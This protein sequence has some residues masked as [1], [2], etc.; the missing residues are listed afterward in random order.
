MEND[1]KDDEP[2]SIESLRRFLVGSEKLCK[3][4]KDES[5]KAG[6]KWLMPM[7]KGLLQDKIKLESLNKYNQY[8]GGISLV[9]NDMVPIAFHKIYDREKNEWIIKTSMYKAAFPL[10]TITYESSLEDEPVR[11]GQDGLPNIY[12]LQD[13]TVLGYRSICFLEDDYLFMIGWKKYLASDID[14][15]DSACPTP[16][17]H[18]MRTDIF[19]LMQ[20]FKFDSTLKW[21]NKSRQDIISEHQRLEQRI[22]AQNP[23]GDFDPLFS[24][25]LSSQTI[26]ALSM[27]LLKELKQAYQCPFGM[28][29]YSSH[30]ER[31]FNY[32]S[33]SV[34]KLNYLGAVFPVF[35]IRRGLFGYQTETII[36]LNNR[37][38]IGP[39]TSLL[40]FME[41]CFNNDVLINNDKKLFDFILKWSGPLS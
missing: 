24:L 6:L 11:I 28:G 17:G 5:L 41:I 9:A 40:N 36:D 1:E 27:K 38:V 18:D 25:M 39:F 2:L 23:L 31:H 12:M 37:L 7:A 29:G 4:T 20:E 19:D 10:Y 8:S 16:S 21:D 33:S 30:L 26:E 22:K 34:S 3:E 15:L 13:F 32:E 35:P 14:L